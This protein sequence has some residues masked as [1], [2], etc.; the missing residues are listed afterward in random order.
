MLDISPVFTRL[1]Q[2]YDLKLRKN[3]CMI[4]LTYDTEVQV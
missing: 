2:M 1:T 3:P 4:E